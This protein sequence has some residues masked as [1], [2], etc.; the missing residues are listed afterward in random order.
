MA[1]PRL[2]QRASGVA[3]R[4]GARATIHSFMEQIRQ[5]DNNESIDR[6]DA[7]DQLADAAIAD[8]DGHLALLILRLHY[9][10]LSNSRRGDLV[11]KITANRERQEDA[12][13]TLVRIK[14]LDPELK[15]RLLAFIAASGDKTTCG[16]TLA[17]VSDLG[18]WRDKLQRALDS[19]S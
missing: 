14:A 3:H 7:L 13:F 17:H 1:G 18:E 8:I 12:F 5:R 6:Q 15:G 2:D 16:A 19:D 4:V 9:D 10:E 11:G